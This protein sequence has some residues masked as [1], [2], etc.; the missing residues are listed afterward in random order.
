[1][2]QQFIARSAQWMADQ[3]ITKR[4]AQT[5]AFQRMAQKTHQ[6]VQ[7]AHQVA[8]ASRP[9]ARYVQPWY[10]QTIRS[11]EPA[12]SSIFAPRCRQLLAKARSRP[13][14]S[15]RTTYSLPTKVIAE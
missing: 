4:L 5:E 11:H 14:P 12:P 2:S 3:I 8:R 7:R 10:G 6:Q 13:S 9:S 1:M 15:R